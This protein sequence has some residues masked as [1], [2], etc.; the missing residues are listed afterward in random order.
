[1]DTQIRE[2][3]RGYIRDVYTNSGSRSAAL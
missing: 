3:T 2:S 1:M